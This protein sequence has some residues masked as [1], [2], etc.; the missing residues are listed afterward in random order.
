MALFPETIAIV[1]GLKQ[2]DPLFQSLFILAADVLSRALNKLNGN[3]QFIGFSM[4]NKGPKINHLSYVD[5]LIL[6]SSGDSKS[7]KLLLEC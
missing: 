7:I 5:D 2:R 4:G 6:F 1:R 3:N